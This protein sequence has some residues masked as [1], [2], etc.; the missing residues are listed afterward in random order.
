MGC[1]CSCLAKFVRE[2]VF[3]Q[4]RYEEVQ[5]PDPLWRTKEVQLHQPYQAQVLPVVEESFP[6]RKSVSKEV[7][8]AKSGFYS[9]YTLAEEI[10]SGSSSKVL[11]CVRKADGASFA[12]K[13]IDKTQ[14]RG[15]AYKHVLDQFVEEVNILSMLKHP[16]IVAFIDSFETSDRIYL[17]LEHL[18]G[19]ELFD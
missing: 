16:N 7:L 15:E 11:R 4:A 10:G 2:I 5:D 1:S 9:A 13:V 6:L 17:V 12:C 18:G 19:G 14:L 3:S 8:T